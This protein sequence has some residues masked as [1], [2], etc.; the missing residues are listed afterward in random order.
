MLIIQLHIQS[1]NTHSHRHEK[2]THP[3]SSLPLSLS[4]TRAI[5]CIFIQTRTHRETGSPGCL[6]S[7]T[8]LL[9]PVVRQGQVVVASVGLLIVVHESVQVWKVT[10]QIDFSGVPS[11]H[12]V[13]VE[14]WT[15]LN[16]RQHSNSNYCWVTLVFPSRV[17]EVSRYGFL[18][19]KI[20]LFKQLIHI[21][22]KQQ[23]K[24][25]LYIPQ[26]AQAIC[27]FLDIMFNSQTHIY[28]IALQH[29]QFF[30]HQERFQKNDLFQNREALPGFAQYF[31][32][33]FCGTF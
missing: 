22:W 13:A 11:T 32:A 7:S 33:G 21:A 14:L 9:L 15:L 2:C 6:P 30:R 27:F 29:S 12:Q 26:T 3:S 5:T 16:H 10:V 19:I 24:T 1:L 18:G 31:H 25:G 17:T 28:F 23:R 8:D 20:Q 4:P